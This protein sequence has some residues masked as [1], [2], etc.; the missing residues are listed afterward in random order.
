MRDGGLVFCTA[1]SAD[2]R[3]GIMYP[4]EQQSANGIGTSSARRRRGEMLEDACDRLF[5]AQARAEAAEARIKELEARLAA[6]RPVIDALIEFRVEFRAAYDADASNAAVW[7]LDQ[8]FEEMDKASL[9][10]PAAG[11]RRER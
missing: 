1:T 5:K 7:A 11:D 8:L 10:P 6:L 4:M 9:G 2:G 3:L